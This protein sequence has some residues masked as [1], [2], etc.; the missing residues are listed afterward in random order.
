MACLRCKVIHWPRVLGRTRPRSRSIDRSTD[1]Q[2]LIA[3]S[4]YANGSALPSSSNVVYLTSRALGQLI[5]PQ[6]WCC[7]RLAL[8][9]FKNI[10]VTT[11]TSPR[12]DSA[13]YTHLS[14]PLVMQRSSRGGRGAGEGMVVYT[15]TPTPHTFTRK[16][17]YQ[18]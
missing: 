9:S 6:H 14:S 17:N 18:Y 10:P 4:C 1:R 15:Q 2:Q 3:P 16:I 12:P 11:S 8:S 5:S 7:L 13:I